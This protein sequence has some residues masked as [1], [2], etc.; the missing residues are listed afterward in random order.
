L[1]PNQAAAFLR[2]AEGTITGTSTSA[3]R[4]RG[5]RL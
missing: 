3:F 1:V 4:F 2:I 5:G